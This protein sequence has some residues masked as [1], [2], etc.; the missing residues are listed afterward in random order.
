MKKNKGL[1]ITTIVIAILLGILALG[2]LDYTIS[3][4]IINKES[5]FGETFNMFGEIPFTFG[6]LFSVTLLFGSR[7]I[8][9]PWRNILGIIVSLPFMALFSFQ[10]AFMPVR[11]IYEFEEAGIP[12]LGWIIIGILALIIF[13][14]MLLF[15]KKMGNQRLKKYRKHGFILLFLMLSEAILVNVVKIFWARPRMR[16]M[17][18]ID[19]FKKWYEIN[20]PM[21]SEEFKSFPSG[22]T[23][24]GFAMI[25]YGL[26]IPSD[27]V[28][29]RRMFTAFA[30]TWGACTALSRVLLGAHFLSDVI[31]GGYITLVLFYTL[32]GVMFKSSSNGI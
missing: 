5:I 14:A 4:S 18:S 9:V 25:V 6:L 28:K 32:S 24:N 1:W 26:F 17:E 2:D 7:K 30:I 11:Y 16:S 3:K 20:G 23:A 29:A 10:M 31:V 27:R 21:N 13:V 12:G 8:E 19:Q 15:I 22:H